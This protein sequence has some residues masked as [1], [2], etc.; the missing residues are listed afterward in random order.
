MD[1]EVDLITGGGV[2]ANENS[3]AMGLFHRINRAL[4]EEQTLLSVEHTVTA[5]DALRLMI[6]NG[7]SQVAV[8]EGGTISGFFTFRKFAHS[9]GRRNATKWKESGCAPGDQVV[10]DFLEP[11]R[12]A[13]LS[14][15]MIDVI[16]NLNRDGAV[17]VG[18]A[19]RVHGIVTTMDLLRYFYKVAGPFVLIAEIELAMRALI[20][21][22]M[23]ADQIETA[24]ACCLEKL[25][26]DRPGKKIPKTLE[27]MTFDNYR[28]VVVD[29]RYWHLFSAT[30]A[31]AK[32]LVNSRLR[33]VAKLR[34]DL[35]HFK[36]DLTVEEHE[37]L[38]ECRD[39]FLNRTL[40]LPQSK[41]TYGEGGHD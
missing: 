29:D 40:Q 25:F 10:A 33:E 1:P 35:F 5:R 14:A 7:Y 11:V 6:D 4:P 24:A 37:D 26:K 9:V 32:T 31:R 27:E 13:E 17:L 8:V 38:V 36:R 2:L 30:F 16:D 12:Y 41:K 23:T 39:W 34:N 19:E 22:C 15:E 3:L 20:Q 18:R 21:R 28:T